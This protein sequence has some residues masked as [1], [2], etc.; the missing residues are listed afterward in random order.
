MPASVVPECA[1]EEPVSCCGAEDPLARV[2][3]SRNSVS[4]LS[5]GC[6]R[7][8]SVGGIAASP[9]AAVAED[10]TDL[11]RATVRRVRGP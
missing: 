9:G 2:A 11:A 1:E 4:P 8:S 3:S 5:L 6:A 10:A 7:M